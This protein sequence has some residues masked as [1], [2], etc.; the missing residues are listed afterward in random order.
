GDVADAEGTKA[1]EPEAPQG[2][3]P[4]GADSGGGAR[5]SGGGC[6]AAAT[7]AISS[8]EAA[9]ISVAKFAAAEMAAAAAK[10]EG[11]GAEISAEA[12]GAAA[13]GLM[14]SDGGSAQQTGLRRGAGPRLRRQLCRYSPIPTRPS[15]FPASSSRAGGRTFLLRRSRY[16]SVRPVRPA[17]EGAAGAAAAAKPVPVVALLPQSTELPTSWFSR[18]SAPIF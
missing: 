12:E 6:S 8:A 16:D 13:C 4:S 15:P 14:V 9:R 2:G 18:R 10:A 5:G 3:T 1:Q 11:K 17:R 7:A